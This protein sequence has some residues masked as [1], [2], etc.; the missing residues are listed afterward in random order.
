L[1]YL[2]VKTAGFAER[3]LVSISILAGAASSVEGGG[4]GTQ[5]QRGAGKCLAMDHGSKIGRAYRR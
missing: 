3:K 4:A 2:A 1:K 5:I